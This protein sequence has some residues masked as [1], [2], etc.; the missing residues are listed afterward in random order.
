MA[1]DELDQFV[2]EMLDAKKLSGVTEDV[3]ARLVSDLKSRLLDQINKAL[4]DALPDDKM[5]A[6]E[7]LLDDETI[8]DARVQQFIIEA[9][10]DVKKVT[11]VTML[12]FYDMY[13]TPTVRGEVA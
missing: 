11:T 6:F 4:I 3:R 13:V 2:N 12:R 10:V 8:D 1:G 7:Q 9:G 5:D